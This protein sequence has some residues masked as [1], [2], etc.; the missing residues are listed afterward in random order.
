[1]A[2]Q[3]VQSART[4]RERNSTADKA[5]DILLMFDDRHLVLSAV[6]VAAQLGVARS[7]AYRYLQSLVQ[8]RFIE[9]SDGRGYRLGGRVLELARLAR[10]GMGLSE[11]ARPV[12]SRL[13]AEVGEAVLLTR[14]A[15]SAVICLERE[16]AGNHA[17]RISYERGQVL[18]TNAGAAAHVLLAWLPEPAVEAILDAVDLPAFT[19]RTLTDPAAIIRRLADTREQGYAVSRGELDR[20]VLGVSAPLRDHDGEVVAAI[21]VAAVSARV[22]DER[23]PQLVD[24]VRAAADEITR[25]LVLRG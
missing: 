19:E 13:A 6:E 14:L 18:P 7:T 8:S 22:P 17:V 24:Q 12:M 3:P 4:Y 23:L 25:T 5:L 9:E 11:I 20:D 15:G 2:G 21:S 16:E 1:M 10:R